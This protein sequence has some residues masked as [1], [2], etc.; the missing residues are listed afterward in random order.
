MAL[1]DGDALGEGDGDGDADAVG[2]NDALGRADD[3][4]GAAEPTAKSTAIAPPTVTRMR[5]AKTAN[6]T[7][8]PAVRATVARCHG[9]WRSTVTLS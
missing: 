9:A 6:A 4:G 3:G 1:G 2:A 7:A 5:S 8:R